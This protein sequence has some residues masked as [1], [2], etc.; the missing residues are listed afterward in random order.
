[1]HN[2]ISLSSRAIN[3]FRIANLIGIISVLMVNTLAVT[4]PI[5]GKSTGELSDQY[6][7]LFVPAGITFSIWSIIYL[8]L[9]GFIVHQFNP[10]SY[11][12][13]RRHT[14]ETISK[15]GWLFCISCLANAGW[16]LAWH[17]EQ[18]GFSVC[19]M[20]LLIASL[21]G[22]T[23]RN[24]IFTLNQGW[25][26]N[27]FV[28]IP[29]SIYLG[30]ITIATIANITAWLTFHQWNRWG[31]TEVKW[32]IW[33]IQAGTIITILMVMRRNNLYFAAVVLWAF[34]GIIR[35]RQEAGAVAGQ[36]VI[37]M[38]VMA[39]LIIVVISI[40]KLG[41]FSKNARVK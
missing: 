37:N 22:I 18:V 12:A 39:M 6:P 24:S 11:P 29:F 19:I 27:L 38:C 33:M 5:N 1:M 2:D 34:Y 14:M 36:P 8:L 28:Q 41:F 26:H 13:A 17:Y 25:R 10:W 31:F 40:I 32:T 4:L 20:L 16:I 23:L 21:I 15:T 35:K 7:N 30:W 9:I 3:I